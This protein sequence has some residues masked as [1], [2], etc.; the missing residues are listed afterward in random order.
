LSPSADETKREKKKDM[1]GEQNRRG[2]KRKN[3][4]KCCDEKKGAKKQNSRLR[5]WETTRK[6]KGQV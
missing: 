1:E 2:K 4:D 6:G 5:G 3:I